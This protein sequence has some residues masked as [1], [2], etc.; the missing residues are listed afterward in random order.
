MRLA[1]DVQ[2]GAIWLYT[3]NGR[4]QVQSPAHVTLLQRLINSGGNYQDFY[5]SELT[6]IL[7][8]IVTAS[9]ADDAEFNAVMEAMKKIP[10]LDTAA[11][12]KVIQTALNGA[13]VTVDIDY[14]KLATEVDKAVADNFAAVNKNIDE[15][16][17]TITPKP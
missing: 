12:I 11:I 9:T 4:S 10:I 7:F 2:N 8:Y 14:A 6:T 15:Q 17:Y 16:G 5:G 1:R 3:S 13:D